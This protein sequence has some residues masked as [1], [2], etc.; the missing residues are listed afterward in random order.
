M[1]T[2]ILKN[3]CRCPGGSLMNAHESLV[4]EVRNDYERAQIIF[5]RSADTLSESVESLKMCCLADVFPF[6]SIRKR[7]VYT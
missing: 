3:R 7:R 4:N 1:C 2:A 6:N 5:K